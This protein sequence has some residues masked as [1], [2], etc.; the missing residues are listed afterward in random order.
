MNPH[1]IVTA[2]LASGLS[3]CAGRDL[4]RAIALNDP[5]ELREYLDKHD[6]S[7]SEKLADFE[8]RAL[9]ALDA[10]EYARATKE[11]SP[12][13]YSAYLGME[14]LPQKYAPEARTR[15]DDALVRDATAASGYADLEAAADKAFDRAALEP[16]TR[17][18]ACKRRLGELEAAPAGAARLESSLAKAFLERCQ[19]SEDPGLAAAASLFATTTGT[20][21]PR[22]AYDSWKQWGDR[23]PP[24]LAADAGDWMRQKESDRLIRLPASASEIAARLSEPVA[25]PNAAMLRERHDALLEP[26]GDG[27]G[28]A[29]AET[30]DA[31]KKL[32]WIEAARSYVASC[33]TCTLKAGIESKIRPV[34]EEA[35]TELID[36]VRD[37]LG[38]ATDDSTGGTT[39][40]A[41][42]AAS[43]IEILARLDDHVDEFPTRATWSTKQRSTV[44]SLADGFVRQAL[45]QDDLSSAEDRI[46]ALSEVFGEA[47]TTKYRAAVEQ[48]RAALKAEEE[49]IAELAERRDQYDLGWGILTGMGDDPDYQRWVRG[50]CG[51]WTEVM[52]QRMYTGMLDSSCVNDQGDKWTCAKLGGRIRD[53]S[54]Y[55]GKLLIP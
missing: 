38:E 54:C 5:S 29:C 11:D 26:C 23:L 50:P 47:R 13:S 2:V 40:A 42:A 51:V 20:A 30:A 39:S 53:G 18:E 27:Q 9:K 14:D 15:H 52:G 43:I 41:D 8:K 32:E 3:G 35:I 34:A 49:K 22:T 45:G 25:L 44:V 31:S 37:G 10:A 33:M 16:R 1:W 19:G 21:F 46:E 24:G 55:V 7:K 36:A 48:R 28:L 12:A 6:G 17:P 4:E